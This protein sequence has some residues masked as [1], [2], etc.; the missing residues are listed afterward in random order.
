MWVSFFLH[1]SLF[2]HTKTLLYRVFF[3]TTA[4]DPLFTRL[5][6]IGLSAVAAASVQLTTSS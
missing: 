1:N 4:P 5:E 6:L 2:I 3:N